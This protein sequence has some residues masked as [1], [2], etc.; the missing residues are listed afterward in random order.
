[1]LLKIFIS[2]YK[3]LCWILTDLFIYYNKLKIK[4]VNKIDIYYL[5]IYMWLTIKKLEKCLDKTNCLAL[6]FT[7]LI[8]YF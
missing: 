4:L 5:N 7:T 8:L 6:W 1:M 3:K 2:I